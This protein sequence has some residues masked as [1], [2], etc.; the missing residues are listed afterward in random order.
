MYLQKHYILLALWEN[1]HFDPYKIL[2]MFHWLYN[3]AQINNN[4]QCAIW[5]I[6]HNLPGYLIGS[7]QEDR[8]F[9]D[10][11][12][13]DQTGVNGNSYIDAEGNVFTFTFKYL[14]TNE[15]IIS[16][17]LQDILMFKYDVSKLPE[18]PRNET[19][20]K[21]LENSPKDLNPNIPNIVKAG[22][23]PDWFTIN[24]WFIS[25]FKWFR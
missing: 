2:Y 6:I 17:R 3:T 21:P 25:I 14:T 23:K 9:V 16:Q 20:D 19:R 11:I 12:M 7:T 10:M 24:S 1:M 22:L 5:K 8:D 18:E 13:I 4:I 15:R